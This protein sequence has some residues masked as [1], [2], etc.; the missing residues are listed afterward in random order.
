I[1]VE[2]PTHELPRHEQGGWRSGMRCSLHWPAAAMQL[3]E[4]ERP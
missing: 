2:R 3:F 1:L 4:G